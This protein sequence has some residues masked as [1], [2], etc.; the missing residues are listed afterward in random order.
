[1][2]QLFNYILTTAPEFNESDMVGVPFNAIL[3]G[4]M[5]T[6]A[7]NAAFLSSKVNAMFKKI[8]D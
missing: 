5:G 4:A 8:L 2:V 6:K 3:D 7:G 1:M